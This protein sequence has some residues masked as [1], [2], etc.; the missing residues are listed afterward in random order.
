MVQ[1]P[2]QT[3]LNEGEAIFRRG[4]VRTLDRTEGALT[5]LVGTTPEHE[6]T[7][8]ANG[9]VCC[10]C[11]GAG[12]NGCAHIVAA[13]YKSAEDGSLL[14]L[15]QEQKMALGQEMLLALNRAMPDGESVR[16]M[17]IIRLFS[18]GR[19]GLGLQVGQERMY[20]VKS[21]YE[22]LNCYNQGTPVELSPKFTYRPAQMRFSK[23]EEA[24]LLMLQSH[25]PPKAEEDETPARPQSEGRFVLLSGAFLQS[26]MRFFE[27]HPFYLML[28]GERR[29]QSGIHTVEVPLCFSVSMDGGVPLRYGAGRGGAADY[30]ARR[31]LCSKRRLNQTPA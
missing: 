27:R 3:I 20:A 9:A 13:Q 18:D 22:F 14:M 11:G 2:G 28:D 17:A 25:M 4:S 30:H 19:T 1:H 8:G 6:V 15:K 5:L 24:V 16:L 12:E 7:L 26:V 10:T 31:A 29:L 23:E 21:I